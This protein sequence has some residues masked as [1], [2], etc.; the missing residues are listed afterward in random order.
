MCTNHEINS[1]ETMKKIIVLSILL[2]AT[3]M[4]FAQQKA[5]CK[6]GMEPG[7]KCNTMTTMTVNDQGDMSAV[8]CNHAADV[9]CDPATC[10]KAAAEV[11]AQMTTSEGI[12]MDAP[13]CDHKKSRWAF[14]K[15][16]KD[17]CKSL[18]P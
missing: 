13:K 5:C 7:A 17:C 11:N 6:K 9:K 4:M 18:N 16:E 10:P 2:L 15:D 1:G 12:T 8:Q 14:W 3:S